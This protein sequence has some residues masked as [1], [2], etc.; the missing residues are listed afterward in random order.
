MAVVQIS[1]QYSSFVVTD[2]EKKGLYAL[3]TTCTDLLAVIVLFFSLKAFETLVRE[4]LKRRHLTVANM[5]TTQV[6]TIHQ[7][8]ITYT[9]FSM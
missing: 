9:E 5:E 1:K 6:H 3:F 4:I 8:Y 2:N 7:Y